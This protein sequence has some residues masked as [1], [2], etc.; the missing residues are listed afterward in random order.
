MIVDCDLSQIEWRVCAFL[1]QDEVAMTEIREGVDGHSD[2][3][4]NVLELPL[5]KENRTDAKVFLFRTI[6]L[7][8]LHG[9]I[10]VEELGEFRGSLRFN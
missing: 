6:K 8:I 4:V 5:T 9:V 3:C 7:L 10:H 1:A 2:N